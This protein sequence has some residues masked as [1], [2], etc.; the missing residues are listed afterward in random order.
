MGKASS[1]KSE[2]R[3]LHQSEVSQEAETTAVILAERI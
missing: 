2:N 1:L 3:F